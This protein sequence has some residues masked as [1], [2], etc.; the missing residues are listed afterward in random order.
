M[1]YAILPV[2]VAVGVTVGRHRSAGDRGSGLV[3]ILFCACQVAAQIV[4]VDDRLVQVQV[5]FPDQLVQAVIVVFL[6]L[7]ASFRDRFDALNIDI[8]CI[9]IATE[10]VLRAIKKMSVE[11]S[12]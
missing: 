1:S 5:V 3:S 7:Y 6:S 2:G 8:Q 10:T 12:L 4:A 11:P 9:V